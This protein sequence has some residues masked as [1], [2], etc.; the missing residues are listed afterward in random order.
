VGLLLGASARR[1]KSSDE[2]GVSLVVSKTAFSY[3]SEGQSAASAWDDDGGR[4]D[5]EA[6]ALAVPE[7]TAQPIPEGL[8]WTTFSARFF[9]GRRRHDFEA[10]K[11]Y[12]A[13]RNGGPQLPSRLRA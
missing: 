8:N 9:P 13:Y 5:T 1:V 12:E 6:P 3:A 2:R 11:A 7:A 4:P 10:V